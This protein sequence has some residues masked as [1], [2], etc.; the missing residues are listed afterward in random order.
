M[1]PKQKVLSILQL[2][3]LMTDHLYMWAVTNY[4]C[5]IIVEMSICRS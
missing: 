5:K 1:T 4:D 2:E 3:L